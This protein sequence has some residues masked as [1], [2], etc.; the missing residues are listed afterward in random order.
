VAY[1]LLKLEVNRVNAVDEVGPLLP[2]VNSS[3]SH[4]LTVQNGLTALHWA[5]REGRC[6][7]LKLLIKRGSDINS[8]D[9]VSMAV[10]NVFSELLL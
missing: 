7:I 10:D 5:A 2:C 8:R 9:N 6:K 3:K 1:S 4:L